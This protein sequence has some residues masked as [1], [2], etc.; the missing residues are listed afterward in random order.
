MHRPER[1]NQ[2]KTGGKKT[3]I[4]IIGKKGEDFPNTKIPKKEIEQAV[5][6]RLELRETDKIEIIYEA[7]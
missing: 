3:K 7:E 2:T 4:I 1:T 5:R 6:R